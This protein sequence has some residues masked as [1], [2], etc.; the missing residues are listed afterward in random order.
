MLW[1]SERSR[2]TFWFPSGQSP[3][4]R[5]C[6]SYLWG[7]CVS[8]WNVSSV[9]G[10][11]AGGPELLRVSSPA[12]RG[13]SLSPVSSFPFSSSSKHCS[14]YYSWWSSPIWTCLGVSLPKWVWT[15]LEWRCGRLVWTFRRRPPWCSSS[16]AGC[17][18]GSLGATRKLCFLVDTL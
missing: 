4:H 5:D 2:S 7:T 14:G 6:V 9:L 18:R 17:V 1:V 16:E 12:E 10:C 3:R 15:C 13:A 8:C 11:P